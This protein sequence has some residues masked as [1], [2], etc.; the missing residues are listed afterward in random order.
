ME[1]RNSDT[2]EVHEI[3]L[4]L[5]KYDDIFS[6]FDM[7]PY[8]KRALSIDFIDEIKRASQDKNEGE[9]DMFFYAPEEERNEAHEVT[10]KER[11]AEHFKKHYHRLTKERRGIMMRGVSMVTL[12]VI[13]MIVATFIIFKDPTESLLL[14]FLVV[15]LE[16]AAWFL[17]WEGMDLII[18]EAREV[19]PE[20]N[21]YRKMSESHKNLHF[22]SY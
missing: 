3:S 19:D 10:I 18:F 6:D 2:E 7:R 4:K 16:P 9:I 8:S 11:M 20:L 12:G 1:L 14:S 5:K 22:K 15:F 13:C 21:F 17:L